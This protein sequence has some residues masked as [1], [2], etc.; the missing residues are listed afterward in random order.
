M[1]RLMLATAF[2]GHSSPLPRDEWE[3]RPPYG[4][5]GGLTYLQGA[6]N[7]EHLS[8]P[9]HCPLIVVPLY[10]HCTLTVLSLYPT[11]PTVATKGAQHDPDP[12]GADDHIGCH[13][14]CVALA[15]SRK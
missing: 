7:G 6:G 1:L 3:K 2:E 5:V 9:T 13:L 11:E 8:H 10:S 12:F 15:P 4:F 14:R